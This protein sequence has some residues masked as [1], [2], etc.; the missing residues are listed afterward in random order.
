MASLLHNDSCGC[1][2]HGHETSS[3]NS[4]HGHG[5]GHGHGPK[6]QSIVSAV[7]SGFVNY[8]LMF[9][10]CCAYGMIMFTDDFNGQHR[11]LGVK[12][13]LLTSLLAGLWCAAF[14]KVPVAIGGPDLNPVVFLGAFVNVISEGVAS[15]VGLGDFPGSKERRLMHEPFRRLGGGGGGGGE[16]DWCMKGGDH[17]KYHLVECVDYHETLRATTI[18]SVMFSSAVLGTLY[19][20]L[21][22]FKIT[23]FVSYVPTSVQEAFLSCIGYKVFKYALLFTNYQPLQ[24]IPAACIGVT[25]YFLKAHHIGNPAIMIPTLVL[26]PLGIF[27][28]ICAIAGLDIETM[29]VTGAVDN[30]MFPTLTHCDFWELWTDSYGKVDKIDFKAWMKTLPDFAS[31]IVVCLIDCLLKISS[32]ESKLPVKVDKDYECTLHGA[33]NFLTTITGS[34]VGYMQLKFNVI[35]YGVLGN[36][37]DRRGGVVYS[38]LCGICFFG[39]IGHFNY[40]PRFFLGILL[41]L[42]GSGFVAENLWGSRKYLSF[43]EWSEILIILAVFIFSGSLVAAVLAGV[44]LTC[45]SL[46]LKYA[47]ISCIAGRA[48][49]GGQITSCVRSNP[50]LERQLRHFADSWFVV[51]RLKGFVFFATA[52]NLVAKIMK[53]AKEREDLPHYRHLRYIILDCELLDG[54]DAS[55]GKSIRKMK[56][57]LDKMHCKLLWSHAHTDFVNDLHHKEMITN[58]NYAFNSLDEAIL[59]IEYSIMEYQKHVQAKWLE[60]DS[61]FKLQ[62]N[63][64]RFEHEQDPWSSV[65]TK[66][67][68]RRGCPWKYCEQVT[69]EQ[70]FTQLWE[71]G[72]RD[73]G[74]FLIHSGRVA[75][76]S[77]MPSE[78]AKDFSWSSPVAVYPH[79]WFMNREFITGM[80]T[81]YYAVAIDGG[82]ALCW[83]KAQWWYMFAERP[84]MAAEIWKAVVAQEAMDTERIQHLL[85]IGSMHVEEDQD[86]AARE[87]EDTFDTELHEVMEGEE[88]VQGDEGAGAY[89][90]ARRSHLP[91]QLKTLIDTLEI[92]DAF[93]AYGAFTAEHADVAFLPRLP[94]SIGE[95]LDIAFNTYSVARNGV[96]VIPADQTM[97]AL[98]YAGVPRAALT[99][100][101]AEFFNR[102]GFL[103]FGHEASMARITSEMVVKLQNLVRQDKKNEGWEDGTMDC[104][105]FS[106]ILRTHFHNSFNAEVVQG[107]L[108]EIGIQDDETDETLFIIILSRLFK[109]HEQYYVFLVALR[110][111]ARANP[112][113][114]LALINSFSAK[115]LAR[116]I[117][118]KEEAIKKDYLQH[119]LGL[120]LGMMATNPDTLKS[121]TFDAWSS[122]T[123]KPKKET[124]DIA[125]EMLWACDMHVMGV[126]GS[127][128]FSDQRHIYDVAICI[129]TQITPPTDHLHPPPVLEAPVMEGSSK[130]GNKAI[131]DEDEDETLDVRDLMLNFTATASGHF[132][133]MADF[134]IEFPFQ[135]QKVNLEALQDD[136]ESFEERSTLDKAT[137]FHDLPLRQRIHLTMEEP[138][139]SKYA[140]WTANVMAVFI[141]TS[142]ASLFIRPIIEHGRDEDDIGDTEETF[143]FIFEALLTGVFTVEYIIRVSVANA[144]GK[145]TTFKYIIT[146]QNICDLAAIMP[147]YIELIL[148]GF[149]QA[150]RLGKVV[151]VIRVIR[152]LRLARVAR[153]ARLAKRTEVFAPIAMCLLVI[154]GIYMK[155]GLSDK[156]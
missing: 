74:L 87:L 98:A 123:R 88:K 55:A 131:V 126:G 52:Q 150:F 94:K 112:E 34:S 20:V 93:G 109:W 4:G 67:T 133:D 71:P 22:K 25:L 156:K 56:A 136:L 73:V 41:F 105:H 155:S 118:L 79:G 95:D 28:G 90:E 7:I 143:W 43:A 75:L 128:E 101:E 23:R 64:A 139:S 146:P 120:A 152:L 125:S 5:H 124:V 132:Q 15:N 63:L 102:A 14:S 66:F 26:V 11:A 138:T 17:M 113:D 103:S 16:V 21:G 61:M 84:T 86:Q 92:A 18:F 110:S 149:A 68:A 51:I 85:D 116:R 27:H 104:H 148:G 39:T 137:D 59:Y 38:I 82:E 12:L 19:F 76:F 97:A 154:W 127:S 151:R 37:T 106:A 129:L 107:L 32:T 78:D 30:W 29:R 57:D 62:H 108:D 2:G 50:L 134:K 58:V 44:L 122:L 3:S 145:Q 142:V 33:G 130:K 8:L 48:L 70:C 117:Q 24:F 119:G 96:R 114:S 80:P 72:W 140:Y 53:F 69:L 31:M 36:C 77:Q 81:K 111:A 89:D 121:M 46:I 49:R 1:L 40:L 6:P 65:I 91:A 153:V 144:M 9:G 35:N 47:R 60:V 10:L 147:F 100:S 13:N 42:A 141:M 135:V 99:H 83:S 45:L 54:M 115:A